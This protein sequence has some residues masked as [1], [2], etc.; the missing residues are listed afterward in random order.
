M[1]NESTK[2][3]TIQVEA[4]DAVP[5]VSDLMKIGLK[6]IDQMLQSSAFGKIFKIDVQYKYTYTVDKPRTP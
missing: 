5:I 6:Q 3:Q 2:D 1:G 4:V